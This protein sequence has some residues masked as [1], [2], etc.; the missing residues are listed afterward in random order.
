MKEFRALKD[1][2]GK[3][4]VDNFRKTQPLNGRVPEKIFEKPY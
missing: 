3:P 1:N 2:N 4:L